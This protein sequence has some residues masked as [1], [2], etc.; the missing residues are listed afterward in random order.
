MLQRS[1]VPIRSSPIRRPGIPAHAVR[2][3]LLVRGVDHVQRVLTVAEWAACE[4]EA[5]VRQAV[6]EGRVLV[7]G[8]PAPGRLGSHPSRGPWSVVSAKMPMARR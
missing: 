7:P 8:R 2:D 1:S 4:D 3:F 5:L 6:H